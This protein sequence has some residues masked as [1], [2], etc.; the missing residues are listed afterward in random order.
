M[1]PTAVGAVSLQKEDIGTQTHTEGGGCE[2]MHGE[3][4]T[5][6]ICAQAENTETAANARLRRRP[7]TFSGW[8]RHCWLWNSKF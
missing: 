6:V 8:A 1:G 4:H 7:G 3:G 5:G 2:E